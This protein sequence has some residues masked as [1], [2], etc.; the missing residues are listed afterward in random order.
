M[1]M[2]DRLR[3]LIPLLALCFYWISASPIYASGLLI[4]EGGFGGKLE[5]VSHDVGVRTDGEEVVGLFDRGEAG[6][7]DAVFPYRP[8]DL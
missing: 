5:I 8:S 4:A 3:T 7:G 6:A 1:N 2:F